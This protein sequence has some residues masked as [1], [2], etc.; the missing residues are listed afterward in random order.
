MPY[1]YSLPQADLTRIGAC[2]TQCLT[3]VQI[4][5]FWY[6][7][8]RS[9]FNT[10]FWGDLN[11][12]EA[13]K[14]GLSAV[15]V[16]RVTPYLLLNFCVN[17]SHLSDNIPSQTQSCLCCL[18]LFYAGALH[19]LEIKRG[20]CFAVSCLLRSEE[21][22]LQ[23]AMSRKK[24]FVEP[25]FYIRCIRR[26]VVYSSDTRDGLITNWFNVFFCLKTDITLCSWFSGRSSC[27]QDIKFRSCQ[28]SLKEPPPPTPKKKK[29][30]FPVIHTSQKL[31]CDTKL[32]TYFAEAL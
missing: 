1:E 7:A 13:P 12:S 10:L 11:I 17:C 30:S 19:D 8:P 4:L 5:V 27:F 31:D 3:M 29:Q 22:A 23:N 15:N 26:T 16:A 20:Q 32:Q 9:K 21:Q 6:R 2:C 25:D 24:I 18:P 14:A 28:E